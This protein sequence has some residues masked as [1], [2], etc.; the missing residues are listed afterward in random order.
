ME[1]CSGEM[2]ALRVSLAISLLLNIPPDKRGLLPDSDV[3]NLKGFRQL[4]DKTFKNNLAKEA[5]VT[6]CYGGLQKIDPI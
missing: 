4:L 5:A 1:K 3:K 6:G 2:Q